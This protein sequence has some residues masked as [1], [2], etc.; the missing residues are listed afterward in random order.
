MYCLKL[1]A[2][3]WVFVDARSNM[4]L[5]HL[6]QQSI[7]SNL[8]F[9]CCKQANELLGRPLSILFNRVLYWLGS[10]SKPESWK[11][12]SII[13]STQTARYHK[14]SLRV[15]TKWLLQN[16]GKLAVSVRHKLVLLNFSQ[17]IYY[18]AKSRQWLVYHFSLF[19]GLTCSFCFFYF[20]RACKIAA[21]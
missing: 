12:F 20:F 16:T 14:A 10:I 7:F 21:I 4:F 18:V 6:N 1:L 3:N 5:D 11:C 13:I 8:F 19:Q 2:I 9:S 17:S 15:T